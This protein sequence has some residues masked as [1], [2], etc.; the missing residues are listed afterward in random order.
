MATSVSDAGQ[1]FTSKQ[2]MDIAVGA[3][4]KQHLID[5]PRAKAYSVQAQMGWD[6]LPDELTA[7]ELAAEG[8][9]WRSSPKRFRCLWPGSIRCC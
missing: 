3:V 1:R 5:P 7:D 2:S 4:L 8:I 6:S 9:L